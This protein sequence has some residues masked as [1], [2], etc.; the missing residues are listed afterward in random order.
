MS[1]GCYAATLYPASAGPTTVDQ[2]FSS[3]HPTCPVAVCLSGGGSRAM[4]AA[5]GQLQALEALQ[6]NGRSLFS[7]TRI[8]STVSGGSWAGVPFTFLSNLADSDFLGVYTPPEQLTLSAIDQLSPRGLAQQITKEFSPEALSVKALLLHHSG[9]PADMLWQTVVSLHVLAPFGLCQPF[10]SLDPARVQSIRNQTFPGVPTQNQDLPAAACIVASC[11]AQQRPYLVCNTAVRVVESAGNAP[12]YAPVQATP[13]MTGVV[14]QPPASDVNGLPVGGG[15][16]ESF[17][18]NS[19]PQA[20]SAAAAEITQQRP[21]SLVDAVGSSSAF[22]A[23]AIENTFAQWRAL[24]AKFA[25]DLASHGPAAI[26]FLERH[27]VEPSAASDLLSRLAGSDAATLVDEL[28]SLIDLAPQYT[29]WP[30]ASL[31]CSQTLKPSY[32]AD[33]GSLENTGIA[34]ALSYSDVTTIVAFVNSMTKLASGSDQSIVLDSSIPPLFGLQ[35]YDSTTGGYA[36]Y[37]GATTPASPD[38]RNNR[39]FD[40]ASFTDLCQGLWQASGNG[41]FN[42]AAIYWQTLTTVDNPW[43]GVAGGRTVAVLWVYLEYN[44]SWHAALTDTLVKLKADELKLLS[45]F[46]HYKTLHTELSAPEINLLSNLTAWTVLTNASL[47]QSL[48]LAAGD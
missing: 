1:P 10:F 18:F 8:L 19:S 23:A 46:P 31:P 17:A 6:A 3:P 12:A 39:V 36:P 45:G 22:F 9:V 37:A 24:P 32:F 33:G 16:V 43:F 28:S 40:A 38:F 48:F 29:Y 2:F 35:P 7:Q 41:S 13:V 11:A 15:G 20:S 47:F 21:W 25:A 34:S 42:G 30:V 5:L 26:G 44:S 27:G 14:G 4:T